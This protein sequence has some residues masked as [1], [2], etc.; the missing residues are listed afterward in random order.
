MLETAS[1]LLVIAA[2]V[3]T[4]AI[5]FQSAVVAPSIFTYLD[6]PAARKLLRELF[7]RFFRLGLVCG[8]LMLLATVMLYASS[9]MNARLVT[10]FVASLLMV[11]FEWI[12]LALV[13]GINAA[14]DA[15]DAG[16][17]RFARLHRLS[18]TLTVVILLLGIVVLI[19]LGSAI[20][21][22]L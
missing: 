19:T 9:G 8:A 14:R 16:S 2:G 17:A 18:I 3:W 4:G 13:P 21:E 7:P 10:V 22:A 15:G 6:E 5:V 1:I 12:S 11:V 20:G